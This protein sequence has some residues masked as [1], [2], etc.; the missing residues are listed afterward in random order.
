MCFYNMLA[1]CI[2]ILCRQSDV[3]FANGS[4]YCSTARID[5]RG[6]AASLVETVSWSQCTEDAGIERTKQLKT[7]CPETGRFWAPQG[8]E[9][10]S[11]ETKHSNINCDNIETV[12]LSQCPFFENQ[13]TNQ[14]VWG[15][16]GGLSRTDTN[17]GGKEECALVENKQR[18]TKPSQLGCQNSWGTK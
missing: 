7:L 4:N 18:R 1:W 3:S 5:I 2:R 10:W 15:L 9:S 13:R 6:Q 12:S 11:K 14:R 8:I 16:N 17:R